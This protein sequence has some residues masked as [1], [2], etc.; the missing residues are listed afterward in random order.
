[1]NRQRL[2][3]LVDAVAFTAFAFLTTTG[4]L[5]RYV[6]PPGSGRYATLWGLNRHG[7]GDIHFWV[8][9]V[10]LGVLAL[11][12][13]LHWKWILYAVQGKRSNASGARLAL[14]VVGL[15]GLVG[16]A[17]APLLAPVE[18]AGTPRQAAGLPPTI[19]RDASPA[20]AGPA[21]PPASTAP[22]IESI[23][24]S[25]TLRQVQQATGVPVDA[26]IAR[27]G[28]PH[29]IDPDERIGRIRKRYDISPDDVRQAVQNYSAGH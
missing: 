1:M 7:W 21:A 27:L 9:V 8:A 17:A 16:L 29:D 2:N 20:P 13:A 6:L 25:M 24:G 15:V 23:R 3:F 5:S 11:H 26:L 22:G 4:V 12:V 10:L 18:Q 14:G 28:L 19:A